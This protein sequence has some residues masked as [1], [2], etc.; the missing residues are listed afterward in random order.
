MVIAAIV[1]LVVVAFAVGL[2]RHAQGGQVR[3]AAQTATLG[4]MSLDIARSALEEAGHQLA[5]RLNDRDDPLFGSWRSGRAPADRL[6]LRLTHLPALLASDPLLA[7]FEVKDVEARVT[8]QEPIAMADNGLSAI[9]RLS[10]QVRHRPTGLVRRVEQERPIRICLV[11]TPRP[12]DQFTLFLLDATSILGPAPA[13]AARMND[14]IRGAVEALRDLRRQRRQL[15]HDLDALIEAGKGLIRD[16]NSQEPTTDGGPLETYDNVQILGD[17]ARADL[18]AEPRTFVG[19]EASADPLLA[20]FHFFPEK[21]T[22]WTKDETVPDIGAVNLY[23]RVRPYIEARPGG[24]IQVA[25]DELGAGRAR[26][27]DI[28][29]E[30]RARAQTAAAELRAERSVLKER[31]TAAIDRVAR[32]Y[33]DLGRVHGG[34]LQTVG[35]F[36]RAWPENGDRVTRDLETFFTQLDPAE[37]RRRSFFRL[38]GAD[39]GRELLRFLDRYNRPDSSTEALSGVVLVENAGKAPLTLVD[40]TVHGKLA[41]M[42]TGD[43]VLSG[44]RLADPQNDLLV[45]QSQGTLSCEG[46]VEASLVV[47][48]HFRPMNDLAINGALVIERLSDRSL[49][50]GSIANH[51]ARYYAGITGDERPEYLHTAFSPWPTWASLERR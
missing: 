48:G 39:P 26:L 33:R 21:Y 45:V 13:P 41:V 10:A 19:P 27:R 11:T 2:A 51:G 24:P 32:G 36:Q 23:E 25:R 15:A 37:W 43:V 22:V 38:T 49:L 47:R 3:S 31:L 17:L 29:E 35:D 8:H 46:V 42:A 28:V 44:V 6:A 4:S 5:R 34:F 9:L 40:R 12:F 1:I 50:V 18:V 7:G 16:L 14:R 20:D 30:I